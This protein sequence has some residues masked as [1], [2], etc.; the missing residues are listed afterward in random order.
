MSIERNATII[1]HFTAGVTLDALAA[2]FT[3]SRQRIRQIVR[4]AGAW[5]KKTPR[6]SFLGV[7]VTDSTKAA[8]KAEA[9]KRGVSVSRLTSDTL[10]QMLATQTAE[11]GAE[12]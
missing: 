10:E 4:A 7:D 1:G 5:K 6:G 11:T 3:I 12:K 8:L 2:E 9:E